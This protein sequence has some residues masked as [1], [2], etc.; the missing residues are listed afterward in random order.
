MSIR[1]IRRALRIPLFSRR[2]LER[3]VEEELAHHIAQRSEQLR[4]AGMSGEDAHREAAR[5][6]GD[7]RTLRDEC[8][9]VD[10]A[11]LRQERLMDFLDNTLSDVR[12]A[13]RGL[14][15]SPGFTIVALGTLIIGIAA[16][17]AIFSYFNAFNYGALPY[18][19]AGRIIAVNEQR[20]SKP[21]D[22]FSDVSLEALSLIRGA[23]RS[24][25]RV[26]AYA[27]SSAQITT[28]RDAV[29]IMTLNVDTS[30]ITLFAIQPEAG[31]LMTREEILSNAPVA[32]ISD[33]LWRA[34]FGADVGVI[35]KKLPMREREFTIVG[36]MPPGF[37]FPYQTDAIS[38][39]A[40][41]ADS[42]STLRDTYVSV[43]AKL[44]PGQPRDAAQSELTL[45]A[46]RLASA[47]PKVFRGERLVVRDEMLDRRASNFLPLPS[48]FL[49]SGLFLLLIACANV[50]NLFFARAAQRA[51]EFAVRASLGATR[52]R[53]IRF[54]LTE[55]LLIGAIAASL[56]TAIAQSLVKLWLH[57]IPTTGFPSWFRVAV[58]WHVLVFAIAT[59]GLVTV[60]AG[61]SP[62][63]A[64]SRFDLVR[65]LK[66]AS[67]G[68]IS[69]RRAMGGSKRGIVI[70]LALSVV[71]FAGGA[72]FVRSYQKLAVIDIGYPADRIAIVQS[73]YD[74]TYGDG[75]SPRAQRVAESIVR[76]AAAS[77]VVTGAAFRGRLSTILGEADP[78]KSSGLAE[79]FRLIPDGDTTRATRAHTRWSSYVVSDGFFGLLGVRI[80]AGRSFGLGDTEGAD[81]AAVISASTAKAL[82]G[83][84]NPVGRTLQMHATGRAVTVVGVV[85]DVRQLRGGR[86][87]WSIDPEPTIYLSPRQAVTRYPEL[88]A[89]GPGSVLLIRSMLVTLLRGE[90]PT[91][92]VG[93][94]LTLASQFD[95]A[96]LV[97]KVF[98]GVIGALAGAA[99]LLSVIGIYGVV[100]FG[101]AQRTHEIGIRIA[102]GGTTS[103]VLRMI[104]SEAARFVSVG[105]LLGLGLSLALSRVMKILLF[106]VSSIDPLTYAVVAIVFGAVAFFACVIPARRV[107]RVDPLVALRSD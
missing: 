66:G 26:S 69:A 33:V 64:G 14:R 102:L 2:H 101:V 67:G 89:T 42:S 68:G 18:R 55:T 8:V 94:E 30:F 21:Y 27:T 79:V 46:N 54:A 9:S 80:R 87:G 23:G 44:R 59:T 77:P 91:A 73:F 22:V 28:G 37:R 74:P 93:R 106:G 56:G 96:F 32:M 104:A 36:V 107:T 25:E 7:V 88:L 47:D 62:A 20:T 57:F 3:E 49:G 58:D 19:D 41:V 48:L 16:F 5:R 29:S 100:S 15:R 6:F 60:A 105:I 95:Q 1:G 72:L 70:Q 99:L 24:I 11:E 65:T 17:T 43:I 76:R 61:L 52:G 98:G 35:G 85:D 90:D 50:A 78:K 97:T 86:D 84:T 71:L 12:F 40:E 34:R 31:R 103:R 63:L 53:L 51:G 38:P 75:R 81:P 92:F 10:A 13:L 45:V 39:L 83:T 82:W 4:A